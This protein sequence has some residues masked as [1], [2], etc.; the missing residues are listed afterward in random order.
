MMDDE[1]K[2]SLDRP[3]TYHIRVPGELA[4]KQLEWAGRIAGRET[5]P[6]KLSVTTLAAT[7]DQA[8]LI[9]LLR[10]LYAVG[11]PLL[12]VNHVGSD[13]QDTNR[14]MEDIMKENRTEA[15]HFLRSATFER[16]TC[17]VPG[18]NVIMAAR[19]DG[20]FSDDSLRDAMMKIQ[21]RHPLLRAHIEYDED[22][23]AWF[24][25][26][27]TP[28]LSLKV[29]DRVNERT[30]ID[31]CNKEN[32]IA[33][34]P[35]N[36]PLF[37]VIR[38][39]D[40]DASDLILLGQHAA[41]DGASLAFL[42]RDL[43][44]YLAHPEK[45]V[46]IMGHLP[47]IDE[48]A[49]L[50][51]IKIH[52][53]IKMVVTKLTDIWASNEIRF[54]AEDFAPL[55]EAYNGSA[56]QILVHELSTADTDRLV[57]ISREHGVTVNSSLYSA[58]I[59]AQLDTE[60]NERD[61]LGNILLPVNLRPHLGVGEVVGFYAGGEGF[62]HRVTLKK[63]FWKRTKALHKR[64]LKHTTTNAMLSNAKRVYSVPP[65]WLDARSMLSL[66]K[67]LPE[68]SEK[69]GKLLKLGDASLLLKKII[70]KSLLE[71]FQIGQA[72][73]NLGRMEIPEQYGDLKLESL[74]FIPPTSL[75]TEKAIGVLTVGGKLRISIS[76]LEKYL[77]TEDAK[78]LLH[79][80]L[81]IIE[82]N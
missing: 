76:Y 77:S 26:R 71:D 11:L 49:D 73:T 33:F 8:G 47:T 52:P 27:A 38:V 32:R 78:A 10:R 28:E 23:R 4:A 48:T 39:V 65:T 5:G 81:E 43:L 61:Y 60:G 74:F 16:S 75:L 9:G 72:L 59:S 44:T 31:V 70:E 63:S 50:D 41:C 30:W 40:A 67:N 55:Q 34:Q 79:R 66:G 62:P 3:A 35:Q 80:A 24:S 42:M 36:G 51:K 56:N 14:K 19:L 22:H 2:I 21:M 1:Q 69:Y 20:Q 12:S 64:L 17:L 18:Y 7:V 45:E 54:L 15:A 82:K 57:S 58:F 29:Y 37:R 13:Q 68:P 25:S 6:G 53:L 46:E